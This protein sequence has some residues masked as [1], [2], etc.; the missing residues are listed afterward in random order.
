MNIKKEIQVSVKLENYIKNGFVNVDSFENPDD[1]AAECLL[2]L[3]QEKPELCEKYCKII[4]NDDNIGDKYL[5]SS[6]LSHLFDLNKEYSLLHVETE[7]G[8]MSPP[9]LA[10]AMV[11]LC[12]YSNAPFRNEYSNSLINKVSDRYDEIVQE[13]VYRGILDDSYKTFSDIFL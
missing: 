13:G 1:E 9:V 10:T 5:K 2:E 4:L 11:G 6:C 7:V 8:K 12:Q 3:F